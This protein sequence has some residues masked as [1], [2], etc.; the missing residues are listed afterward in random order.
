MNN[1]LLYTLSNLNVQF[2]ISYSSFIRTFILVFL[3]LIKICYLNFNC[4]DPQ[5][6]FKK[7]NNYSY[8]CDIFYNNIVLK[9]TLLLY[10]LTYKNILH[11]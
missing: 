5:C 7:I 6:P 4:L 2:S 1:F 11:T 10:K 9:V 8:L 3:R